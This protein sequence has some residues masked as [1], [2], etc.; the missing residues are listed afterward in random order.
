MDNNYFNGLTYSLGD[1]DANLELNIAPERGNYFGICGSGAR[2]LPLLSLFPKKIICSDVSLGQIALAKL[3]VETIRRF[4]HKEYCQFWGYKEISPTVRRKMLSSLKFE[5]RNIIN[6]LFEKHKWREPIYYGKFEKSLIKISKIV[7]ALLGKEYLKI[8]D[9]CDLEEQQHFF[10]TVFPRKRFNMIVALLGNASFLNAILYNGEFPKKNI[11]GSYY[12]NFKRV[13]ES[14][15]MEVPVRN[16]YFLQ[17]VLLGKVKYYDNIPE[18]NFI[19]Y[20]KMKKGLEHSHIEFIKGNVYDQIKMF[21]TNFFDYISLSDVPSFVDTIN[22]LSFTDIV[23]PYLRTGGL[24]VYNGFLKQIEPTNTCCLSLAT[25]N[26][27]H[28]FSEDSTRLW[29]YIILKKNNYA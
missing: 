8:F 14:I 12:D 19:I 17:L 13:F 4:T 1:E 3:R 2:I 29:K 23:A 20:Q 9:L 6:Q 10:K 25:H 16:S 22:G 7:R 21:D 27:S 26:Y 24:L 18:A 15:F 28:V 5:D 11:T